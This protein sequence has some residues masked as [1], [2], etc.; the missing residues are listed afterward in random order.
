M[1]ATTING[2][3]CLIVEVPENHK[4]MRIECGLLILMGNL[5]KEVVMI[6]GGIFLPNLPEGKHYEIVPNDAEGFVK[7]FY[8]DAELDSYDINDYQIG[9]FIASEFD[10]IPEDENEFK[11]PNKVWQS[12]KDHIR[13]EHGIQPNEI[14]LKIVKTN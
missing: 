9:Y 6:E 7:A 8:P 1:R 3:E 4:V 11:D 10:I 5:P 12:A 14:V 2:H 13:S